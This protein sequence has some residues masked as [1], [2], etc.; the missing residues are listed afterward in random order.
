MGDIDI[1]TKVDLHIHSY[2]SKY[3]EPPGIVDNSTKSNL[4]VLFEKLEENKINMFAF[5]DHNRFDKDLFIAAK[6]L[7]KNKNIQMLSL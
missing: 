6:E 5:S 3:K 1:F 4:D 2:I 7:I